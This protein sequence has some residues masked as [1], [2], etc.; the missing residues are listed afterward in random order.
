MP[1]TPQMQASVAVVMPAFNESNRLPRSLERLT[2]EL[3]DVIGPEWQL[4]VADDGST[5]NTVDLALAWSRTDG[6]ILVVTSPNNQGKGAAVVAGC[7]AASA[8]FIVVL[9]ADL[10][11]E[12]AELGRLLRAA[13]TADVVVGSRR[14]P[15]SSFTAPQPLARRLGGGVFLRV[16]ALLG[17]RTTSDPQCGAKVLRSTTTQVLVDSTESQGFAFDIE[18]LMRAQRSGL[19]IVDVPV[20]W[21]HASGS[22]IR[23]V[24]DGLATVR[25]LTRVR[26]RLH[27]S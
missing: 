26:R 18:L 21:H 7:A 11:I 23:P 27:R 2:T 1:E 22:S 14:L 17:L 3:D 10:P 8:E 24:R 9:D 13:T 15:Q 4:V 20:R 16:V 5:D 25:E 12:P 19:R 6:R